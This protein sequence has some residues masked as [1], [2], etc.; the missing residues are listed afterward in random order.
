MNVSY[1]LFPAASRSQSTS[2]T[3]RSSSPSSTETKR[4]PSGV[5][6]TISPSSISWIE[7]VSQLNAGAMA[8]RRDPRADEVRGMVVM[9]DDEREVALE[10]AVGGA[11][12]LEQVAL[13]VALDQVD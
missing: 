9:D 8:G 13:V 4:D 5:I 12:R 6:E 2:T 1:P 10:L 3:S 7:R 11:G